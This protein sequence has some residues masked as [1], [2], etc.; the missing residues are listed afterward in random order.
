MVRRRVEAIAGDDNTSHLQLIGRCEDWMKAIPS[1]SI[2]VVFADPPYV[3]RN[4][5]QRLR[6]GKLVH[7]RGMSWDRI[8]HA[9]WIA[10]VARVLRHGGTAFICCTYHSLFKIGTLADANGLRVLNQFTMEK[11]PAPPCLT[12]RMARQDTENLLWFAK[13]TNWTFNKEV[14]REENL[15]SVWPYPVAEVR[16]LSH[17]TPKPLSVVKRALRMSTLPGFRVLDPFSGINT[18]AIAGWD[19]KLHLTSIELYARY[20][21]IGAA[22]MRQYGIPVGS[23]I[24]RKVMNGTQA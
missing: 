15:K 23:R 2:D 10:Q 21:R 17:E 7:E 16:G 5:R 18:V 6:S 22:R 9:M 4:G 13:G 11:Q 14:L 3:L 12:A 1:D 20:A 24:V 19:L 8:D